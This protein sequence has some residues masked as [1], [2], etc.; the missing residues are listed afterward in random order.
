LPS[1]FTHLI[2]L[3]QK[4]TVKTRLGVTIIEFITQIALLTLVYLECFVGMGPA[5]TMTG[6]GIVY[7][8]TQLVVH[9]LEWGCL[10]QCVLIVMFAVGYMY[11]L[12]EEILMQ[13]ERDLEAAEE[14]L[15]KQQLNGTTARLTDSSGSCET[16][17]VHQKESTAK[18]L[19]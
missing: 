2:A 7:H 12:R 3:L 14:A 17:A 5:V 8:S 1:C 18:L 16:Q 6:L 11:T 10:A 19:P 15:M 4:N 13:R 9:H